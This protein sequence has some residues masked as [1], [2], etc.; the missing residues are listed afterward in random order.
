MTD[1]AKIPSHIR[2]SP[3]LAF[4]FAASVGVRVGVSRDVLRDTWD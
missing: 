2:L 3:K 4:D 1:F